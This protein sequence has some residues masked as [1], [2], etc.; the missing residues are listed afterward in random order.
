MVC[1]G[2]FIGSPCSLSHL[3]GSNRPMAR[4]AYPI[5]HEAAF[6]ASPV[7]TPPTPPPF[8]L[9]LG[10]FLP[11]SLL[12][13]LLSSYVSLQRA[14]SGRLASILNS[15]FTR[16]VRTFLLAFGRPSSRTVM[17]V[18]P[19]AWTRGMEII[20]GPEHS[21]PRPCAATCPCGSRASSTGAPGRYWRRWT[22][23]FL[24]PPGP[25]RKKGPRPG[26]PG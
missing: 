9:G 5:R 22:T 4:A 12:L 2:W 24:S 25:A 17:G 14:I 6:M 8:K 7:S 18:A 16:G 3:P 15:L 11:M 20:L 13:S 19:E 26:E 21:P 10:V 1:A 23:R